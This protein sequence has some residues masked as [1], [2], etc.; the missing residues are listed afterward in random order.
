MQF[1][2]L[3]SI[4][5]RTDV[6]PLLRDLENGRYRE[7]LTS[8]HSQQ[9]LGFADQNLGEL[10]NSQSPRHAWRT[11]RLRRFEATEGDMEATKQQLLLIG[12]AALQAFL[13]S[14]VT[15]PPLGWDSSEA[16]VPSVLRPDFNALQKLRLALIADLSVD[17]EAAYQLTPHIELFSIALSLLNDPK[18]CGENDLRWARVRVNFWHQRMLNE[19]AASLQSLIYSDL[20]YLEGLVLGTASSYCRNAQATFLLERAAIHTHHGFDKKARDDLEQA[21]KVRGFVYTLT[22]RLGK[23][24]KFQQQEITQ[25][26]VLAKSK[27]EANETS[28]PTQDGARDKPPAQSEKGSEN[29]PANL[30]L[31]DDTLLESIS[32]SKPQGAIESTELELPPTLAALDPSNQPLLNPLDSILLLGYASSITNTSPEDGLTREETL[33][34]ATRVLD[35]GSSNWQVYTQALLVR[36]RIEGYRSRTIE[37]GVLQLQAL[38]DQVI[39]ETAATTEAG[40]DGGPRNEASGEAATSFLPRAKPSESAPV[41]E[42][43]MYISQLASPPRW[44][45]E[46]ELAARWVS[47]GGLRTA[48]EIYERLELWAE[49]ALCWAATDREDKASRI[50]RKQLYCP[51]Q[52]KDAKPHAAGEEIEEQYHGEERK[53]LP[54]DA[55]RLF[56]ILGDL[57]KAKEHYERAWK[58]SDHRYARAQRSLGKHYMSSGDLPRSEEAYAASLKVNPQNAGTWFTLGCVRLELKNWR[59]AVNAFSRTVS[60]EPDDGEAWS[61]LAAALLRLPADETVDE[62]SIRGDEPADLKPEANPQRHVKEAFVAFKRA[63]TLKRD[64]YR[65]WQNVLNVAAT[66]SPPPYADVIVAQQRL[67]ELRGAT[68]G[69]ACVDTEVLEGLMAHIVATTP[70]HTGSSADEDYDPS[71][72]EQ[73]K[74]R[75]GLERAL[76][77][78]LTKQVVPLITRSRRL[79][80]IVARLSIHLNR[81]TSALDAYEKA[82]RLTLNQPGWDDGL[83]VGVSADAAKW[84]EAPKKAWEEVVDATIELADAYE[85]LGEREVTEGPAAG[86]GELVCKNWR[87]KGRMAVRSVIGR[88]TKAGLEGTEVLQARMEDLKVGS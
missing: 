50:V 49:A 77:E 26:V 16:V 2:Y 71:N 46:A 58:I 73:R 32:F 15:G 72:P 43:L 7:I 1:P 69:E 25:L 59:G 20:T 56:C 74:K 63:A 81:P 39:A 51:G 41:K 52:E 30:N 18:I 42:R 60:S 19:N 45:L 65:I 62:I 29:K 22:G 44:S 11:C 34:Y 21:T 75:Y 27:D 85:S 76:T 8:G 4:Q 83:P 24:T 53:P 54:A 6:V 12:H 14:N 23:R 55:P 80:Q 68:E 10:L 87:Y 47:L 88:R 79:W 66:I 37:R 78:L 35:S 84:S 82:W 40:E 28:I 17:G 67:I 61:N 9:L 64:S 57:E 5:F 70:A 3:D 48:L 86:S 33:P 31:N 36:S 13:Q 38:V